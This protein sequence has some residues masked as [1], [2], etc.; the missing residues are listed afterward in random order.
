MPTGI[1]SGSLLLAYINFDNIPT[2]SGWPAGWEPLD[3]GSPGVGSNQAE[4]RYKIATGSETTFNLTTNTVQQMA[5]WVARISDWHGTTPPEVSTAALAATV[6][7]H[8]PA[9]LTP[10]WGAADTLWIAL[11][12]NGDGRRTVSTY[13]TNY[14]NGQSIQSTNSS[15]G[16]H[17]GV[18]RRELNTATEDPGV[19][20]LINT[21]NGRALTVGIRPASG[22]TPL[23]Y[24]ASDT[25]GFVD[26]S[27]RMRSRTSTDT[28]AL[29][30]ASVRQ[31]VRALSDTE[32]LAD[33]LI[34]QR[35]RTSSDTAALAD[36]LGRQSSRTLADAEALVDTYTKA[37]AHNRTQSDTQALADTY[38]K[39]QG[40]IRTIREIGL[41]PGEETLP[42]EG[43]IIGD[44]A[45]SLLDAISTDASAG[46]ARTV[47]DQQALADALTRQRLRTLD[48]SEALADAMSRSSSR[49]LADTEVLA[50]A[51]SKAQAFATTQSDTAAIVDTYSKLQAYIR[52]LADTENLTDTHF[53]AGTGALA[54]TLQDVLT[55][56]DT[57][58]GEQGHKPTHS[59]I[60]AILDAYT[61]S[62]AISLTF[63]D[64]ESLADTYNS[65]IAETITRTLADTFALNDALLRLRTLTTLDS[66]TIA[67]LAVADISLRLIATDTL[68]IS[69]VASRTM[70]Y[71][72]TSVDSLA[73]LDVALRSAGYVRL[74]SDA[75][76]ISDV[77]TPYVYEVLLAPSMA[78]PLFVLVLVTSARVNS[79]VGDSI[80]HAF[81][82]NYGTSVLSGNH[83]EK[84]LTDNSRVLVH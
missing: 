34:S 43:V 84:V 76:T 33:A 20:T 41:A 58:L 71:R 77:G 72:V 16:C 6:Q 46:I 44:G 45:L 10:S 5:G 67:D 51:Y 74:L 79:L 13:P 60:Q 18:A 9:S 15:A 11:L 1:V 8:N 38:L 82:D 47:T 39:A 22:V 28:V 50:D 53:T 80:G 25:L 19:F 36:A 68:G 26:A 7:T 32:S 27:T 29:P 66:A 62:Q 78:A 23:T 17:V 63:S 3:A 81:S 57:Y 52:T 2:I 42:G 70:V 37:E 75:S 12:A 64:I 4:L 83:V 54:R 69:D 30:D 59:D 31:R 48:E 35:N 73:L 61:K 56:V 24:T 55:I 14:T 65:G 21:D 49:S 40:Y